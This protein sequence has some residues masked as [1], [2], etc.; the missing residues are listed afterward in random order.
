M[1]SLLLAI[2]IQYNYAKLKVYQEP[3]STIARKHFISTLNFE[4]GHQYGL[5]AVTGTNQECS[6]D[7]SDRILK[8]CYKHAAPVIIANRADAN[9]NKEA[10]EK[11]LRSKIIISFL[12][13][14]EDISKLVNA[15][16]DYSIFDL[17][18]NI[19]FIVCNPVEDTNW[20]EDVGEEIWQKRILN[21]FIIYYKTQLEVIT[22]NPFIGKVIN[23]TNSPVSYSN[24]YRNKIRNLHG[25]RLY[26]GATND[27]IRIIYKN[28]KHYGRDIKLMTD[29]VEQLNA[30]LNISMARNNSLLALNEDISSALLNFSVVTR[31]RYNFDEDVFKNSDFTYPY[32]EEGYVIIAPKGKMRNPYLNLFYTFH[33]Y[34][35]ILTISAMI[36]I[37]LI[38]YLIDNILKFPRKDDPLIQ[39][40]RL[41]VNLPTPELAKSITSKKIL[42][43]FSIWSSIIM[44]MAFQS[45]LTS[46]L[47]TARYAKDIDTLE[48]LEK[49]HLS[50]LV[51]KTFADIVP[52]TSRL[53]QQFIYSNRNI[54]L[55][56]LL[57]GNTNYAYGMTVRE[58]AQ[59]IVDRTKQKFGRDI[60]KVVRQPLIPG[61]RGYF[62][63]KDSPYLDVINELMS[64]YREF[65]LPRDGANDMPP[66]ELSRKHIVITDRHSPKL[67][68][69]HLQTAFY[70]L[71]IGFFI[72]VSTL[73][74][75]INVHKDDNQKERKN[76]MKKMFDKSQFHLSLLCKRSDYLP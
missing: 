11:F 53:H 22:Y 3:N 76:R 18:A 26:A 35:W 63:A 29:I 39:N 44:S 24:R 15:F 65:G 42:I 8:Q 6:K 2:I 67:D 46:A 47:V 41:F 14:V 20:I 68:I 40:L 21:F 62:F 13:N 27:G 12:E 58:T 54:S 37:M 23:Y 72:A 57:D 45:S 56:M 31:F 7:I 60:F 64:L 59:I 50:I 66:E 25:Y 61:Y 5:V 43:C 49:S 33:I 4:F 32:D 70:I 73:F 9:A 10:T 52:N 17:R 74:Y 71:L 36:S 55:D 34:V 1:S 38:V 16:R 51:S 48:E 30:T 69:S 19:F 28:G 75:E